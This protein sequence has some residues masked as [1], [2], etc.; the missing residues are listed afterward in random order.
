MHFTAFDACEDLSAARAKPIAEVSAPV[1]ELL[2]ILCL[3]WIAAVPSA[4]VA[5][6]F[7]MGAP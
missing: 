3:L 7:L 2:A 5:L 1:M 4:A 6:A